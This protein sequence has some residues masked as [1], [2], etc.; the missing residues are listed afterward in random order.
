MASPSGYDDP[1]VE[2]AVEV[3]EIVER[4]LA[5]LKPGR[6][7]HANVEFYAGVV[8][9]VAGLEPTMF[10][11]YLLCRPDGRLDGE[12]PRAGPGHKDHPPVGALCRTHPGAGRRRR[13]VTRRLW[14]SIRRDG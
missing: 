8:M 4:T 2:L 10:T 1:L 9:K 14:P 13:H 5:A 7:L 12:H 6:E 3:E 11:P